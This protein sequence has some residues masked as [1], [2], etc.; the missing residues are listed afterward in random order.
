MALKMVRWIVHGALSCAA[1]W[2]LAG[3]QMQPLPD[4]A[5]PGGGES[6]PGG[7]GASSALPAQIKIPVP[8]AWGG[9]V[10]CG[11]DGCMLAAVEHENG[12]VA[13]HRID[14][15]KSTLL[16]RLPVAYH[17]DSAAWLSDDM[18]AVA[19]ESSASLDVF[20]VK[21]SKLERL[22]K[23]PVGFAPRDVMVVKAERGR[24]TLLATP[25]T[26]KEVA[27]VMDWAVDDPQAPTVKKVR[28]CEAPWHPIKLNK[29]RGINGPAIAVACLDDKRLVAVPTSSVLSA[30]VVL[31]TFPAVSRNAHASPTGNWVYVSLETGARNAR[32]NMET[33]EL[34]WIASPLTGSVSTA[35]LEDNLVL[36]GEDEELY[37]QRLDDKG[38][39]LETRWL[40]VSGFAT[41]LQ[42]LDVDRDGERDVVVFNSGGEVID[43]VY[44][45]L[46]EHATL[47]RVPKQ[48]ARDGI[49]KK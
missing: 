15:R 2:L 44:G 21:G 26:G 30:P 45:P 9:D 18:L 8:V 5:G 4:G 41:R 40:G 19:V 17:P 12:M 35:S 3:C 20:R 6:G 27:W 32:V 13:V 14:G 1:A 38:A 28:W 33:G 42:V 22:Q 29:A 10:R 37:L 11:A 39:V 31:A 36:W 47:Q 48:R 49:V 25:Y 16:D 23:I 34:Q 43:V 24:Y 7:S 46:W